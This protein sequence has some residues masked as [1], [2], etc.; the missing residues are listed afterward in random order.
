MIREYRKKRME[1]REGEEM[2]EDGRTEGAGRE[3]EGEMV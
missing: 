2:E 1:G 3:G